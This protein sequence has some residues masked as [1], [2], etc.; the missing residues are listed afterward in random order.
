MVE[1]TFCMTSGSNE[2]LEAQLFELARKQ[3][4]EAARTA[5]LDLMCRDDPALRKG[6]DELL[7]AHFGQQHFLPMTTS[8]SSPA[9]TSSLNE[10]PS[11][12]IGRYELQ[13][14]LGEG[15]FGEVWLAQQ[16]EPVRRRVALKIIKQGMDSKQVVSRFE[17][18]RQA[19]AMMDHPNIAKI[20]DGGVIGG[21]PSELSPA[22]ISH[23]SQ[24]PSGRPYFVMELVQGSRITDYCDQHQLPTV[25]RIQLF[26]LVC[27]AV[28]HAHQ[29]GIIH[30]DLKPSN[31]LVALHDGVPVPKVID[32]G[33]AKAIHQELSDETIHTQLGQLIG[34]PSYLSPEQA[35]P[36]AEDIDTRSDI[37]SLGVLLYE[38]LV[39]QTPFD[40]K[41][42]TKGGLDGLRKIIREK[43]P[44]RPST[45]LSQLLTQAEN[46]PPE[47]TATDQDR[48][49][50]LLRL[51]RA[52]ETLHLLHG[53]LDWIVL[54]CLEKN[55]SRRYETANALAADLQR[56]LSHEPIV[57]RPPSTT[58]KL[59]KAW[60]RNKVL[61]SASLIVVLTLVIATLV[62]T[63]QRME[64]TRSRKIAE[65]SEQAAQG[66]LYA[67]NMN[68][69]GQAW[70]VNGLD[71]IRRLL[72]DTAGFPDRGF[73]WYYWQ[74]QAHLAAKTFWGHA[75]RIWSAGFSP[76]GQHI[77]TGSDDGTAKVW[78]ISTGRPVI[79]LSGHADWVRSAVFS[80]DGR[81]IATGS[82]D[83]I[84]RIWDAATGV[85]IRRLQGHRGPIRTVAFSPD[86]RRIVT[87][88]Q[89]G[90]AQI[91][92]AATG[93]T[94]VT[95][96]GHSNWVFSAAFSPDGRRIVTG[97]DDATVR[98]WD[99]AD[100]KELRRLVGHDGHVR[101]TAFSPNGL[102]VVSAGQDR[103]AKI[104]DSESG[105]LERTL[106]GHLRHVFSA[107][108]SPD[109]RYIATAS[110]DQ[111]AR[112]WDAV[113]GR[114]LNQFRGHGA[115]IY[116][117]VFSPDGQRI[118]TA[119][120]DGTSKM[121]DIKVRP[122][123]QAMEYGAPIYTVAI[124]PDGQRVAV[125]GQS[126]KVKVWSLATGDFL[127]SLASHDSDIRSLAFSPNGQWI[128]AGHGD[129]S[130]RVW[131]SADGRLSHTLA[132]HI[133]G[134]NSV[135]FSADGSRLVTAGSEG[136]IK[137]WNTADGSELLSISPK[138]GEAFSA[139]FS[140]D[141]LRLVGGFKSAIGVWKA[142]TG[143]AILTLPNNAWA[144]AAGFSPDGKWILA[145]RHFNS[146]RVLNSTNGNPVHV[147]SAHTRA[148]LGASFSPDGK[149][150]LT[151]SQDQTAKVWETTTGKEILSLSGHTDGVT[152]AVFS[153]NGQ[154]IVTGSLD[155]T[156]LVWKAATPRQLDLWQEEELSASNRLSVVRE[157]E[158]PET[159][160]KRHLPGLVTR[161]LLLAPL[162]ISPEGF[163]TALE[164]V[165][166]PNEA[167]IRPRT[168]ERVPWN[169]KDLTWEAIEQSNRFLD[170]NAL[171]GKTSSPN[172]VAYAVCYLFTE[173]PQSNVIFKLITDDRSKVYL[174]GQVIHRS[175]PN[176]RYV[177][178]EETVS[179]LNLR[180][181]TNT[182]V[183][184]IV[185]GPEF[186]RV[187][188]RVLDA[189]SR[190][191]SALR[192]LN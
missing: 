120:E 174:N 35:A 9:Q 184:K 30:R 45:K 21:S 73:E 182:V 124:S 55:R 117:A 85:E 16:Q 139:G 81:H 185:N 20:F 60:Q 19:L 133:G 83:Y 34:T 90:T 118:L 76:D 15:G 10:L 170:V 177:L 142:D 48:K 65:A 110:G 23:P 137:F 172:R 192:V 164:E 168:R 180:A 52:K 37:Y 178:D 33:I 57:A 31:I 160:L 135:S 41:E 181:G 161:W 114:E 106:T 119:S 162:E 63:W 3:P 25:D 8:A 32:F 91:W 84:L 154:V 80:P 173:S 169:P 122:F 27:N 147:L 39:G 103:T 155:G 104:W 179:G 43:E 105:R 47:T 149:R 115:E 157:D 158:M 128:A 187:S 71:R 6:V 92:D 108:F 82:K 141:G 99:A 167:Q 22:L 77:V 107:A 102:Q 38:L 56:H 24:L 156:A 54:K 171:V 14:K 98:I 50:A 13:E 191:M 111:T 123:P 72:G 116:T 67:A 86:S 143:A 36:G 74:R 163:R 148:V 42:M 186:W 66:L 100:G 153:P 28:Q 53:D 58:Y 29:K 95:C 89:D 26:I 17:A 18:E 68:L 96:R 109:G 61:C 87:A 64:A 93:E 188:L 131:Q 75:S 152:S 69:I 5:F 12:I 40:A 79:T 166:I 94:L 136:R 121:W 159:R 126:G 2:Q 70:E 97:G 78:E 46:R 7:A 88:S 189:K 146:A 138:Y 11:Q 165:Q 59:R 127:T 51:A 144:R 132:G 134:V 125:G 145:A 176:R 150:I 183:F 129:G 112:L 101:T 130:T 4:I 190:E 62:S 44:L 151:A 1:T 175:N 140:P 49:A 113:S